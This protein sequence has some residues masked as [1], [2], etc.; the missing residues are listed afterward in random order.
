MTT[1]HSKVKLRAA[2]SGNAAR[3]AILG[4]V[5]M[6]LANM[7]TTSAKA[8]DAPAA[9]RPARRIVLCLDGTWN[10]TFDETK[11][12]DGE[13]VLKPT[14][15]LKLC[16]AVVP[17]DSNGVEQIAYYDTGVGS[18][19]VYPG[20]ANKL[21]YHSDRILGGAFGA[22]FE[23]NVE[24]ALHFLTMNY[25]E[26]DA[27]FVFGFSRGAGTARAVT[28]FLEWNHGL[29]KKRDAY[30]LPIL[31]REYL[32]VQGAEKDH[33]YENTIAKINSD[34]VKENPRSKP[35][36]AFVPVAVRYLG[37]WDTVMALGSRLRSRG[38]ATSAKNRAF[39]AGDAPA[40]CVTHA[41]QALAI[42]E[43]RFDFRPEIWTRKLE[44]QRLE[45]RWFAGVHSNVG[46]GYLNDGLANISFRW[47]LNGAEEEGLETDPGYLK[48][49][50]PF[51]RDSLYE[52]STPFYKVL[53][54]AR[55]TLGR[56]RRHLAGYLADIDPG[57]I[58][59]MQADPKD[60]LD[61]NDQPA[62][63]PYRPQNVMQFL[64]CVPSL[65]TFLRSIEDPEH[66]LKPLPADVLRR[67]D[68]L[69]Q[70]CKATETPG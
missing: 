54:L 22:G 19:S 52:S 45:Q 1:I 3:N 28:R 29:P 20:T 27:V 69:R 42:D 44:K 43:A 66:P 53:D 13:S 10:G 32:R 37:V 38:V 39:F 12:R 49:Y 67:I 14:N 63:V 15:T 41:R 7:L 25:E 46:G 70:E 5:I 24:D 35:L 8:D 62:R 21:L 11:R 48:F 4:A 60:L 65:D 58:Q 31:F 56:G 33:E 9:R 51:F 47:I 34:R 30:Y 36:G 55:S 59:R 40:S 50:R 68:E 16:R 26:G 17:F 23:A 2:S 6:T 57:V 64:A 18:L 61:K